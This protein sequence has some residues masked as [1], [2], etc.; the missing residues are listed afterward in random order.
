MEKVGFIGLGRMGRPMASNLCRKGF[1]LI[2]HDINPAAGAGTRTAAGARGPAAWRKSP[3]PAT[4]SSPCCRTRPWSSRWRP[5]PTASWPARSAARLVMDMST[6]EPLVPPTGWPQRRRG[7]GHRLRRCAGRPARE[8]CRSRRVAVHG[9]R[10]GRGFRARAAAAR[11]DGQHH[12]SLRRGRQRHR[13][14]LVNNYPRR[15]VLPAQCRGAGA[16]A[17]LRPVARETLEVLYGTTAFNGQLK[18]AW[19]SR[20]WRATSS[21]ASPSISPTRI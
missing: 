12:P 3:P 11:G 4:S 7:K 20:C 10:S 14:K 8:P 17:A 9:R 19:P 6:V 13:T 18:I 21:R 5:A 2:V 1:R 15:R 16:V